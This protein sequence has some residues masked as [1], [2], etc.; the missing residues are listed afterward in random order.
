VVAAHLHHHL[1]SGTMSA[2]LREHIISWTNHYWEQ[3]PYDLMAT[4]LL[5]SPRLRDAIPL[6]N[7]SKRKACM[8]VLNYIMQ[9]RR[10]SPSCEETV[11][12]ALDAVGD[13]IDRKGRFAESVPIQGQSDVEWWRQQIAADGTPASRAIVE[14]VEWLHSI[15]PHTAAVERFYSR[16][17]FMQGPRRCDLS[18]KTLTDMAAVNAWIVATDNQPRNSRRTSSRRIAA[19]TGGDEQGHATANS[20]SNDGDRDDDSGLG[21]KDDDVGLGN[22]DDAE[23]GSE[24]SPANADDAAATAGNSNNGSSLRAETA[25]VA[26]TAPEG[27]TSGERRLPRG[28]VESG[29]LLA[30]RICDLTSPFLLA[31]IHGSSVTQEAPAEEVRKTYSENEDMAR[32]E[33]G[34]QWIRRRYPEG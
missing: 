17:G 28:A 2:E 6:R 26:S 11:E 14:I 5:L 22:D 18:M 31:G 7:E 24:D 12:E 30:T 23:L 4:A 8:F 29:F 9:T 21:N 32:A 15:P 34:Q 33:E 25:G 27:P 10:G 19:H 16:L 13:Y 20:R 3:L 1:T